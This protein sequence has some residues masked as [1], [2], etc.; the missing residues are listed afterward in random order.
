MLGIAQGAAEDPLR[1]NQPVT[2]GGITVIVQCPNNGNCA[3]LPTI[4]R[5]DFA[6]GTWTQAFLI[7]GSIGVGPQDVPETSVTL[8]VGNTVY[9]YFPVPPVTVINFRP[10]VVSEFETTFGYLK[11]IIYN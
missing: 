1:P 3:Q 7:G 5:V 9:F 8:K 4:I 2:K 6:P 11:G 10:F